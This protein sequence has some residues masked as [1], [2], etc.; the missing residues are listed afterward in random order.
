M[1]TLFSDRALFLS[2]RAGTRVH[3]LS[4]RRALAGDVQPVDRRRDVDVAGWLRAARDR[5]PRTAR[6]PHRGPPVAP[7]RAWS[8]LRPARL[9]THQRD[10]AARSVYI[11]TPPP[12]PTGCVVGRG[13]RGWIRRAG[14]RRDA[15]SEEHTSELQSL[16]RIS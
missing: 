15:R 6:R 4:A 8:V 14:D 1:D 2:A 7:A 3:P 5:R 12:A 10:D 16:M 11:R 13:G 9:R